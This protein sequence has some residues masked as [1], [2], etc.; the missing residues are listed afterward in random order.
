MSQKNGKR[1]QFGNGQFFEV[2]LCNQ[3]K[4]L[5]FKILYYVRVEN[6]KTYALSCVRLSSIKRKMFIELCFTYCVR[7]STSNH[8]T[9]YIHHIHLIPKWRK[10]HYSFVS[11]LISPHGLDHICRIQQNLGLKRGH[12]GQLTFRQKN[13]YFVRHFGIRCLSSSNFI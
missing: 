12:E 2:T 7:I 11:M 9:K 10:I 8:M 1:F 5:S 13:N 3:K 4:L 6:I